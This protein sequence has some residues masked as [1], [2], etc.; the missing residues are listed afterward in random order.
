MKAHTCSTFN[1]DRH[2]QSQWM[3]VRAPVG[4][5]GDQSH[6]KAISLACYSRITRCF[7][8]QTW[9]TILTLDSIGQF[10]LILLFISVKS[11]FLHASLLLFTR[12]GLLLEHQVKCFI[13][14]ENT[15]PLH[16]TFPLGA[17]FIDHREAVVHRHY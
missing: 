4:I 15:L 14:V 16:H 2:C 7:Y 9:H 17:I 3:W 13:V 1:S 5:R 11:T 8:L 6:W 12:V 10:N